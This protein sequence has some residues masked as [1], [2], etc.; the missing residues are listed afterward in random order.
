MVILI[1]VSDTPLEF[2]SWVYGRNLGTLLPGGIE[3]VPRLAP[4]FSEVYQQVSRTPVDWAL[5]K[6][7]Q[8]KLALCGDS[9]RGLLG[10]LG[11]QYGGDVFTLY[12]SM[13]RPFQEGLVDAS[14]KVGGL[15]GVGAGGGAKAPGEGR[16]SLA[17]GR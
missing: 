14:T 11:L 5:Y 9:Y 4:R 6:V 15:W 7:L 17:A 16:C 3:D 13:L 1:V 12:S 10:G 8:A 2:I